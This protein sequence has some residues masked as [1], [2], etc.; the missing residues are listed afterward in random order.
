MRA[1]WALMQFSSSCLPYPV[2]SRG[3]HGQV[4]DGV[5]GG[6]PVSQEAT[7]HC[8]LRTRCNYLPR[9]LLIMSLIATV[10]C[11]ILFKIDQKNQLS[12]AH[13]SSFITC[14]SG[15]HI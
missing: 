13:G 3:V 14:I 5:T 11:V 8:P 15:C 2:N 12:Y 7:H 6:L 10:Y 1:A 9:E 4:K